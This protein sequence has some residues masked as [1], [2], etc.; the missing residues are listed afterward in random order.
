M[1]GIEQLRPLGEISTKAF[2]FGRII[3]EFALHQC[4]IE[5]LA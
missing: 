5:R 1:G 4:L 3:T 2:Y